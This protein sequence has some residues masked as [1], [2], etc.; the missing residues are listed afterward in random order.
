[1]LFVFKKYFVTMTFIGYTEA[2]RGI[3]SLPGHP[4]L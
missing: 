2:Y 1:M 3:G 4:A